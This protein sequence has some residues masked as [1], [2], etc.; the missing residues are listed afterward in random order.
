[1]KYLL[2]LTLFFVSCKG[3]NF[4]KNSDCNVIETKKIEE[5][6]R[7]YENIIMPD[8]YKN[9]INGN[10][11]SNNYEVILFITG[12]NSDGSITI[13]KNND[14]KNIGYKNYFKTNQSLSFKEKDFKTISENLELLNYGLYYENCKKETSKNIYLLIVKKNGIV[15]SKYLTYHSLNFEKSQSNGNLNYLKNILEIMYRNSW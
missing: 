2:L 13:L 8:N 14:K 3:Q 11:A 5:F 4:R 15:V 6:D 12:D 1:M 9:I 10:D 7:V